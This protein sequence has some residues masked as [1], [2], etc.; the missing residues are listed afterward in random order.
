MQSISPLSLPVEDFEE[1]SGASEVDVV[2]KLIICTGSNDDE[3][4]AITKI[5]NTRKM[6]QCI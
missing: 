1:R 6:Y 3:A 4:A 2:A 5:D